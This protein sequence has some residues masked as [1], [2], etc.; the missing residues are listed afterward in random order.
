MIESIK[1]NNNF[2]T[3]NKRKINEV[4]LLVRLWGGAAKRGSVCERS[5]PQNK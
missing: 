4:N 2:K 1:T 3:E 5:E